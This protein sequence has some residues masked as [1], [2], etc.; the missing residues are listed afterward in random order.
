MG[1]VNNL[2]LGKSLTKSYKNLRRIEKEIKEELRSYEFYENI[3]FE[4]NSENYLEVFKKSFFTLLMLSILSES[5]IKN[6]RIISYG[7]IIFYLRQIVTSLDN[8]L[9]KEKKGMIFI[10]GFSNETIENSFLSLIF[11]DLMTKEILKISDGN[12]KSTYLILEK[13]YSIGKG[14][15]L[16]KRK[17][18][19][20]Y[21][22]PEY[23][24]EYI[25]KPI[26]GELLEISLVVPKY[27]E[28]NCKL[29]EFSR[30]LFKIGMSLQG[31]DDF[32][33]MEEDFINN[34]INLATGKYIKKYNQEEKNI[35]FEK[36]ENEFIEDYLKEEIS[37]ANEGFEILEKF[38]FPID[39]RDSKIILK[40]LFKIR[41][42]EEY[43]YYIV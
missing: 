26:G 40:K 19:E 38:G 34:D 17:L 1:I 43:L 4:F 42:L 32:F 12:S 8:I 30:G 16:R 21:P 10:N 35:D 27:L 25:H 3:D 23:I 33:D 41:G 37:E 11:Q 6:E 36:L 5:G 9:D 15:S 13:L 39:N 22:D 31:I 2:K 18:Y 14:E 29:E 20:I 28:N 24:Y 7:K